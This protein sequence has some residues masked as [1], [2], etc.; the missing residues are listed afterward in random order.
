MMEPGEIVPFGPAA[1]MIAN[2]LVDG[3]SVGAVSSW[4]FSN[5]TA[6]RTI[7]VSFAVDVMTTYTLTPSAGANGSISPAA[8]QTVVAGAP[9]TFMIHADAGFHIAD[10]LVDGLS[11][12][13]VG[14]YS[15]MNVQ[16]DHTI[17][18]TFSNDPESPIATRSSLTCDHLRI[19]RN[20]TVRLSSRLTDGP[21][22][23]FFGLRV[24]YEVKRP[25]SRV[26]RL[27]QTRTAGLTGLS[28]TTRVKLTTH[29]SYRFRVR[30]LGTDD[31]RAS[32]SRTITVAVR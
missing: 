23:S 8:T 29:G 2:V 16:A 10:V 6:D 32:T 25:G 28:S 19:R 24:R 20:Q 5:V 18:A 9:F 22:A 11:V 7:S 1:P 13:P 21:N 30:F 14:S 27:L 4:T 15:L 31:F 3:A 12:G 17:M 26:W